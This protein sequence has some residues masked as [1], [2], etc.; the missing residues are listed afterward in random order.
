MI[1]IKKE[2]FKHGLKVLAV[3]V[4]VYLIVIS[5]ISYR[6]GEA[7]TYSFSQTDWSDGA[8]TTNAT[9][10]TDQT[11]WKGFESYDNLVFNSTDVYTMLMGVATHTSDTDFAG[12]TFSNT[13]VSGSG[14]S[15]SVQMIDNSG[16]ISNHSFETGSFSG[17]TTTGS[18]CTIYT[19]TSPCCTGINGTYYV[20]CGG[21]TSSVPD[22]TV[23]S[24]SFVLPE[25]TSR[26]RFLASRYSGDTFV[27]RVSD[28]AKLCTASY[29]GDNSYLSE[30]TCT[31]LSS[32]VGTEVYVEVSWP[33][34][35]GS[36]NYR[37]DDYH[38]QNSSNQDI[39]VLTS[40]YGSGTY[41]SNV[42]DTATTSSFTTVDYNTTVP[43]N[44]TITIDV[45]A[46]NVA[47]PDGTWTE[48]ITG[49]SNGGDI[50]EL[51]RNRYVQYVANFTRSNGTSNT[52]SL[53]DITFNYQSYATAYKE[54][55][56]VAFDA[57]TH[58]STETSGSGSSAVVE[59]T[60][61]SVNITNHDFSSGGCANWTQGGTVIC[62]SYAK[63]GNT[64]SNWG[65]IKSINFYLPE[66]ASKL[67]YR[68]YGSGQNYMY[69]KRTSNDA[70]LCTETSIPGGSWATK[71][72]T[73]LSSYVGTQVY[74]YAYNISVPDSTYILVDD[75][76]ITNSSNQN[77]TV[78]L[79]SSY[80]SAAFTSQVIDMGYASTFTALDYNVTTPSNTGVTIDVRAGNVDPPDGSWQTGIS[81]GGDI[82]VLNGNRYVQYRANF[83]RSNWTTNT[84]SLNDIT[85]NSY[86]ASSSLV[87]SPYDTTDSTNALSQITW[88]ETFPTG[89]DIKFQLRTAPDSSGSPGTWTG[90]MGTDGTSGTYFTD[91][92]GTE[93]M[94][95]A[96]TG[97]GDDQ[98][99]QYKVFFT[100]N[101][102]NVGDTI[103][104]NVSV[105]Y[106]VNA[107]PEFDATYG[108]N[109]IT[110]AQVTDTGDANWNN[111]KIDYSIRDSDTSSGTANPGYVT[112]T[113]EYNIGGGWVSITSEYM[114]SGATDNK[115]VDDVNYTTYTVYWDAK[116]QVDE[117]YYTTMQI[118]LTIDDNEGANNTAQVSSPTTVLDTTDPVISSYV[119]DSINDNI[120]LSITSDT[121]IDYRISNS[122]DYSADGLNA[123]S[124]TW[125]TI[126]DT[127]TSSVVSWNFTGSPSYEYV[128]LQIRDAYGNVV[129]S[130]IAAPATPSSFIIKDVSNIDTSDYVLFTTWAVY[131]A[132]SEAPFRD[133]T[134][135]RST[136]GVTYAS[137]T[138]ITNINDNQYRDES[139]ASTTTYYYKV[140]ISTTN[141]DYSNYSSVVS[142]LPDGQG[143]TDQAAPTISSVTVAETQ[144]TWARIT[145]DTNELATS[146]IQYSTSALGDYSSSK[147]SIT[148]TSSHEI[149]IDG[150]SANTDYI[151][152]VTA[153][154]ETY[155][156]RSDDNSG[157]GYSFT[158]DAGTAISGVT[159]QSVNDN[160][161]VIIWNTD[162][163]S[164]GYVVYSTSLSN[165][166]T[167]T[168]TSETGSVT[169]VG[170]SGPV[171]QH[172]ITLS[173]LTQQTTYYYY[174]KSTDAS[175]N[176]ATDK[177]GGT[178]YSF[179]TTYDTVA[180]VI[181]NITTPIITPSSMVITWTTDELANSQVSFGTVSG[182]YTND[183]T[184]DAS[185]TIGHVATI[186][187]LSEETTHYFVVKS[188]DAA[189][190]LAT[191]AE[192]SADTTENEVQIIIV[193]G[194]GGGG[195]S[196]PVDTT[197]PVINSV[198]VEDIGPFDAT[199]KFNINEEA[200]GFVL[201]GEGFGYNKI[202]AS[203]TFKTSHSIKLHGLKLGTDYNFKVAAQDKFGNT[204]EST[205]FSFTTKFATEAL[206][207]LITLEN[208]ESFQDDLEGLIESIM[209]SLVPPFV[210][211]IKISEITES[212]AIVG[213][214]TN[215]LAYGS[216]SYASESDYDEER[217]RPYA[218]ELTQTDQK[219]REHQ[220]DL[221]G[222]SPNTL[223]HVRAKSYLLPGAP[224]LSEDITFYTKASRI[225]PE[226]VRVR[227]TTA[228][229]RWGTPEE[230]SSFVEYRNLTTGE[231][232]QVGENEKIR[233]HA[234]SLKNLTPATTYS[235]RAFGYDTNNNIVE[236]D[237]IRITTRQDLI[238]PTISAI[239]INNALLPGRTDRLQTVITWIT[240]EPS[241]SI[242]FFEEGFGTEEELANKVGQ[243]NEFIIKHGVIITSMKPATVYRIQLLSEDE[244][245]NVTRSPIRTILTPRS[246][247]SIMDIIFK[248]LEE[249]FGFL[250]QLQ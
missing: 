169:L 117:T 137:S 141:N 7:A 88:T 151:F 119:I 20:R 145:F 231:I 104:S 22:S 14:S 128:S 3:V 241:N 42:V 38:I 172:K 193:S 32:Y 33:T 27:R 136:D 142:D 90:W 13:E 125:Q 107:V 62:S 123:L 233:E 116:S 67:S 232:N 50:S 87:S 152:R 29:P 199:V 191:S 203:K 179:T 4:L 235:I 92:L 158:T 167:D 212:S 195:V 110:V 130:K 10:V 122:N 127:S 83:T 183:T 81:D 208:L 53:D 249:T 108:T 240:D 226:A 60:D 84:A 57:G 221:S 121:N 146:T 175:S 1:T 70:A 245:G 205:T 174:V 239:Q 246:S 140:A 210:S 113:Y 225:R 133:Y 109:G 44:T 196:T 238:A 236:G 163:D 46:G 11:T 34:A 118:R 75:F 102:S 65:T 207:E 230:T 224:G 178:Y 24:T 52:P 114:S 25:G 234:V 45:R 144:A 55:S 165:V 168:S 93:A 126:G 26:L 79:D 41:T 39:N 105:Q 103:L 134:V 190:N 112:P 198:V 181:S 89:A 200:N 159:V 218:I 173:N 213:W 194:G 63:L 9:H 5:L 243:E 47:T 242:V 227:N 91:P 184:L 248:N 247:E 86:V 54:T 40:S 186:E 30:T 115:A 80:S 16:D 192:Q 21:N 71:Y 222:L 148:Y 204:G 96:F 176:L 228:E 17:W 98:W 250:R 180:P 78:Y 229:I 131:T 189:G 28:N 139:V 171:Y 101:G 164:D 23:Q 19:E 69:I 216:L 72:C 185:L 94:P 97:G 223:Y 132:V 217:D 61:V 149:I 220:V 85:F 201:Y 135:Y 18:K 100:S 147:T 206:E 31:G 111:V 244:S 8:T 237:P 6:T 202:S 157:A 153:S 156:L 15:A 214:Q 74:A 150:L 155:N 138:T 120:T 161:A 76:Y 219:V 68:K 35:G 77:L 56:D 188:T 162:A 143:G 36:S 211:N 197:P 166:Q 129:S 95:S 73:G 49:I 59:M 209:P 43:S 37:V 170:G 124:G 106:V 66:G 160:T 51:G 2:I 182:N 215:I 64:G 12:A 177:N 99:L 82:S 48:W 187:S 58:S 154:D